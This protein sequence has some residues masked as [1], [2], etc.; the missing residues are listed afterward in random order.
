MA[1]VVK[2]SVVNVLFVTIIKTE[3]NIIDI[4]QLWKKG[5][6]KTYQLFVPFNNDDKCIGEEFWLTMISVS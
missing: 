4:K 2:V 5:L 6:K 3:C 1:E